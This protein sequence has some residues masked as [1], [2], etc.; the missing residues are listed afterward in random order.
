MYPI[1]PGVKASLVI[2][3]KTD[4]SDSQVESFLD[5]VL[6]DNAP[7]GHQFV[8]KSGVGTILRITDVQKHKGIAVTF[9]EKA[10]DE[11]RR[12][13]KSMVIASP[14]VYKIFENVEPNNL[15]KLD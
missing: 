7:D 8:D 2:F 6:T 14:M 11:Q 13:I 3:F 1:G 4:V 15:K 12:Q 5:E 10:T 9:L